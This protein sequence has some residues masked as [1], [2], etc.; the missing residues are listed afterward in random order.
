MP[1]LDA[2]SSHD[3]SPGSVFSS[4]YCFSSLFDFPIFYFFIFV[5]LWEFCIYF[6]AGIRVIYMILAPIIGGKFVLC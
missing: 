1:P 3:H 4:Q 5:A 6:M 2:W